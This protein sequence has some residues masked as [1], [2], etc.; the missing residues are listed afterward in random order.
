MRP[1]KKY[2]I[3]H[4][5]EQTYL[6]ILT[7]SPS[8][9]KI[10]NLLITLTY[11]KSQ[12]IAWRAMEAIGQISK[13]I[14]KTDPDMVRNIVGRLLWMIRDESGGIGW[15]CPEML[16]EIVRNNPK[17]C[18]DIAPI[19]VSF[20][21]ELMLISGV[22]WATG[23]IGQIND[24]TVGYAIP[25]IVPY[26]Q[27][28]DSTLRAYAAYALGSLGAI[29]TVTLL[30]QLRKDNSLVNFYEDGDLKQ[31]TVGEIAEEALS[32]LG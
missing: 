22:L 20:H 32:Q 4:L 9:L 30:G 19:I 6:E 31:K 29:G 3:R 13:E 21:E 15:S 24:E 12:S 14:A 23:R 25:V 2:V 8:A 26:L 1:L 27:S 11:D 10:T 16:G 5:E 17:L 7:L 18:A 28:D